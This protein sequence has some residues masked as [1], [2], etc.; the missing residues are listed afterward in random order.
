MAQSTLFL[1]RLASEALSVFSSNIAFLCIGTHPANR[2][3]FVPLAFLVILNI[4]FHDIFHPMP[5]V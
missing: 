5:P 3:V 2:L 1:T 4:R